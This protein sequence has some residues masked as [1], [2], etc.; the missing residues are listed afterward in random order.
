[1]ATK[2]EKRAYWVKYYA[3]NKTKILTQK[4]AWRKRN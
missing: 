1:M 2:E 4:K 3:K